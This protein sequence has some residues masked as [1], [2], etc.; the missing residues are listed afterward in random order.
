MVVLELISPSIGGKLFQMSGLHTENACQQT[1]CSY[2]T[3]NGRSSSWQ[4]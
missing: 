2:S 4:L 3:N 1:K